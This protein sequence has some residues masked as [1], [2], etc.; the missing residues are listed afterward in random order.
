MNA[1]TSVLTYFPH[2]HFTEVWAYCGVPPKGS[3]FKVI[4]EQ[5]DTE[6]EPPVRYIFEWESVVPGSVETR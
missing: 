1:I 2:E 3:R 5:W 6:S 4:R